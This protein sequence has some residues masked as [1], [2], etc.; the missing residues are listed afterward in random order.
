MKRTVAEGLFLAALAA[1][2]LAVPAGTALWAHKETTAYYENRT[3]AEQPSPTWDSLWDGSFGASFER[4]LSDHVPGRTTLLKTDTWLQMQVFQ[5]PVVND[6]VVSQSVL[7]P[8]TEYTQ[9]D[10]E[11]YEQAAVPIAERFRKLNDHIQK[12]GGRFYFV[13]FPE[14]GVYFADQYP[15]DMNNRQAEMALADTVF[16]T[17][18]QEKGIALLK[19]QEVYDRMGHPAELYSAVDHHYHYRGAYAAYRAILDWLHADGWTLPVLT[20]DD[21]EFQALPNPYLG[22]RNRK[23]YNLWANQEQAVIGVQKQPVPFTRWDNGEPS[24]RP[25]FVYPADAAMPTTYNL[26]MGGDF[27]ETIL[28]TERPELPNALIIGD[29]FTNA[30]ETLLYA[31]FNET[32]SLDLRHYK[33][34]SLQDYLTDY[35]PDIVLFL[36]NDTFYYT[37]TGNGN[38]WED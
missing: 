9:Y 11:E 6:V 16:E 8:K 1:F 33:E 14:Q 27:G 29:S 3:L 36:E 28:R 18:L 34:Q 24:Q 15:S 5:R 20:E 25:L 22:S 19:M 23:L 21:L 30:L 2:F 35:Q 32:R 4:W 26:Y 10:R 17:A 31:S 38:V 37:T 7:L 12:Q 13:G